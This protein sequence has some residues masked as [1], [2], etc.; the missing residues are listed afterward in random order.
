[1]KGSALL[2]TMARQVDEVYNGNLSAASESAEVI[3]E[4]ARQD[5]AALEEKTLASTAAEMD[6]LAERWRQKAEAEAAR[7]ALVVQNEA[8]RAVLDRV[9]EEIRQT[10]SGDGFPAI[11][12]ALLSEL[13]AEA[14]ADVIALAPPDHVDRIRDWLSKNGH[15]S[16]PVES[17]PSMWDGLAV[18]D[19]D[20]TFRFSNTLR[21]R[22]SR[23]EQEARKLC[24]TS[25][26]GLQAG[27]AG[28]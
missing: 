23:V 17:T 25:L 10:V 20:R 6:V 1:M 16:V 12:D 5:C 3:L 22:F 18:Q 26:F 15:G 9:D 7:A 28:A 13:I 8:V 2:D 24:M 21:G 27:D 4:E 11:L 14:P 19:R